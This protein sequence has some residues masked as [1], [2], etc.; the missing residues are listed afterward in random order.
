VTLGRACN[1]S[2]SLQL[3]KEFFQG[4]S[5]A[6][7]RH[8]FTSVTLIGFEVDVIEGTPNEF[9]RGFGR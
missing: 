9:V 1:Q 2:S 8:R 6:F 5:G 7:Q 4:L 3:R